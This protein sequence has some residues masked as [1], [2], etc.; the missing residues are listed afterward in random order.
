MQRT[1]KLLDDLI[2]KFGSIYEI[3]SLVTLNNE[4]LIEFLLLEA[5]DLFFKKI[6]D[7]FVFKKDEFLDFLSLR[8]LDKSYTRFANKI[9][10]SEKNSYSE[11]SLLKTSSKVVLNFPFKDCILKGSQDKDDKKSN[12]IF[13][14]EILARDEID[15]LFSPKALC[16][17]SLH[18]SNN[19]NI[20]T[21]PPPTT[22]IMI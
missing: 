13:F 3:K 18:A 15:V 4:T 22:K 6:Q 17:F 8:I 16:N 7:T 14:N 2:A 9:G 20:L 10:L 19:T 5:K 11:I 12:E 21:P 1:Q